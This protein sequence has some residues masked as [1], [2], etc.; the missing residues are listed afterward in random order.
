MRERIVFLFLV[1]F[2]YSYSLVAQDYPYEI[3][4]YPFIN[5]NKNRLIGNADLP[6]FNV[7]FSQWKSLILNGDKKIEILHIGDSHIQADFFTG[8]IRSRLQEFFPGSI[9][10]R[11]IIFPY[12]LAATN[13]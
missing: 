7:F 12:N 5:Y 10:A 3:D 8:R 4:K 9:G 6:G 11:G 13:N 1:V 2:F